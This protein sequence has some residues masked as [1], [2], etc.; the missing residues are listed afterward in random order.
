MGEQDLKIHTYNQV[1][2]TFMDDAL[3]E[4]DKEQSDGMTDD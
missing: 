4:Q 1:A 3:D 2:V